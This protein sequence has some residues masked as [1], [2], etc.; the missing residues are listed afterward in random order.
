MW[1]QVW[2]DE[3]GF[4]YVPTC[5]GCGEPLRSRPVYDGSTGFCIRK[6]CLRKRTTATGERL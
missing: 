4:E 5:K 1:R 2:K 3:R 6:R